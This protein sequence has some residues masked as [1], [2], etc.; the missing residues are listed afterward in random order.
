LALIRA[1]DVVVGDIAQFTYVQAASRLSA[2]L[3]QPPPQVIQTWQRVTTVEDH[4]DGSVT[5]SALRPNQVGPE[6]SYIARLDGLQAIPIQVVNTVSEGL[7]AVL[8]Q[9]TKPEQQVFTLELIPE[10]DEHGVAAHD[11]H[12]TLVRRYPRLDV[13][14][15]FVD[16]L[17][18]GITWEAS[19]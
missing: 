19:Q 15:I 18:C 5:L 3:Q 13:P 10:P 12:N 9:Q 8:E 1:Q 17:S 14:A 11:G 2:G 7:S 4:L 16:C 6:K